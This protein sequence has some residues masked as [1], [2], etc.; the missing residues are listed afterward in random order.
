MHS[1]VRA[2]VAL[3]AVLSACSAFAGSYAEGTVDAVTITLIDLDTSDGIAPSISFNPGASRAS[4]VVYQPFGVF[5]DDVRNGSGPWSDVSA[6]VTL[7]QGHAAAEVAGAAADGSGASLRASGQA[8]EP[9]APLG[10]A[11]QY[12]AQ[13]WAPYMAAGAFVLSP[14]TAVTFTAQATLSTITQS[15]AVSRE[16]AIAG[17]YLYLDGTGDVFSLDCAST[18]GQQCT[19]TNT[20]QLSVS[21]S[22]AAGLSA[23]ATFQAWVQAAGYSQAVGVPEPAAA[24]MLLAGLGVVAGRARRRH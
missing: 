2:T 19:A 24:L 5:D 21:F 12:G 11:V 17:A 1:F 15:S 18:A 13:A 4:A 23:E 8:A 6:A 22:N 10:A 9:G 20:R 3:G 7:S 14:W 16:S